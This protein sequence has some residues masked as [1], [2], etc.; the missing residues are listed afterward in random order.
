MFEEDEP[1]AAKERASRLIAARLKREAIV[2]LLQA[3][4]PNG[5]PLAD[6]AIAVRVGCSPSEVARVRA[7]ERGQ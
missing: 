6:V 5:E 3:R 4:R 1:G 7:E 2:D